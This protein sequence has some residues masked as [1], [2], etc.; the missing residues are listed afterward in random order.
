MAEGRGFNKPIW[1]VD[2]E[3]AQCRIGEADNPG[4]GVYPQIGCLNPTGI[5][6]KGQLLAQLPVQSNST[7]WAI[8]ETHLTQQGMVQFNRELNLHK[9][10][11]HSQ[12]GA[13]VPPKSCTVSA[14]GGRHRGV[15]FISNTPS[16]QMTQTWSKADWCQNR[17]QA[18]C[19]LMA[20]R[21]ILV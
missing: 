15:G 6:G 2:F 18:A 16:R 17:I 10:G 3:A 8:S 11:M 9:V 12:L 19:F 21:W 5:L 1:L 13:P 20:N 14:I 4:P 7:I